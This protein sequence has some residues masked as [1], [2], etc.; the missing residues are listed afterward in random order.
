MFSVLWN[1]IINVGKI[2]KVLLSRVYKIGKNLFFIC[3]DYIVKFLIDQTFFFGPKYACL[4][5]IIV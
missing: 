5:N 1:E 4:L 3:G 2:Q